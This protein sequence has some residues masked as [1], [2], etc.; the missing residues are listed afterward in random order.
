MYR[1]TKKIGPI[2]TG[3]RQWRD[4]GHCRYVHGYG[5]Y[6]QF[7]FASDNLDHRGWVM[8]FGGLKG[9][10]KWLEEQWDHR[11]L[12]SSDDPLLDEFRKIDELGG[13]NINVMDVAKGYGP[14]IE[15]SCKFVYDHVNPM[16]LEATDGK[17][18]LEKVEVWEHEL[19]SAYYTP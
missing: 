15:Q 4:D 1:S 18:W 13:C 17:A 14:G 3:H 8:D 7:T 2:S 6:V 12:L 9:V 19:N 11:L 16:I 10:K 5:R